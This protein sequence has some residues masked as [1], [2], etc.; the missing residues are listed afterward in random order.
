MKDNALYSIFEYNRGCIELYYKL[1]YNIPQFLWLYDEYEY[2]NVDFIRLLFFFLEDNT[3]NELEKLSNWKNN[4]GGE[5]WDLKGVSRERQNL[6]INK[7]SGK[8]K[9]FS[10]PQS[11]FSSSSRS[12]GA[13]K[14]AKLELA[15]ADGCFENDHYY[16][17]NDE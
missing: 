7:V 8:S 2:D 12:I 1:S 10:K 16:D 17:C 6:S 4:F 11:Y 3:D 9:G 13:W 15:E 5:G 14:N